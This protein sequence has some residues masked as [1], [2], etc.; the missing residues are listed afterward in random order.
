MMERDY[1]FE[2]VKRNV[3]EMIAAMGTVGEFFAAGGAAK[4]MPKHIRAAAELV[5]EFFG[6]DDPES[7][8]MNALV[9]GEV[10]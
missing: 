3:D 8:L 10:A 2:E 5:A 9:E 6:E 1:T 7:F 4:G